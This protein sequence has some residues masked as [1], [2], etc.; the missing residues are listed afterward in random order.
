MD[1]HTIHED[2]FALKDY[3]SFKYVPKLAQARKIN[4]VITHP[5]FSEITKFHDLAIFQLKAKF[6]I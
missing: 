3:K 1:I 5:K 6:Y 2:L 4:A